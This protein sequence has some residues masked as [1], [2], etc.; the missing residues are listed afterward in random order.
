MSKSHELSRSNIQQNSINPGNTKSF[1][2]P[3]LLACNCCIR[4]SDSFGLQYSHIE[5]EGG[6]AYVCRWRFCCRWF[7]IIFSII[8]AIVLLILFLAYVPNAA[9]TYMDNGSLIPSYI[10]IQNPTNVTVDMN[11]T[12]QVVNTG[13]YDCI[14]HPTT[15]T[16]LH[17]GHKIGIFAQPQID[18]TGG[19][20]ATL[21][22]LA[23]V[24]SRSIAEREAFRN[25]STL[26]FRGYDQV[27]TFKA[28]PDVS[29]KI[30]GMKLAKVSVTMEK[31]ISLIG[32]A[33]QNPYIRNLT[34]TVMNTTSVVGFSEIEFSIAS[35]LHVLTENVTFDLYD[36]FNNHL[37]TA[38]VPKMDVVPGYNKVNN[39]RTLMTVSNTSN[40]SESNLVP[41]QTFAMN[42]L[43][44]KGQPLNMRG[45]IK[46]LVISNTI[47]T[48][49]WLYGNTVT[50]SKAIKK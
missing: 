1:N 43:G 4:R 24:H 32:S 12:L 23:K 40:T 10:A 41:M 31:D 45:P 27:I 50:Q 38:F 46:G 28:T 34:I 5:E 37:G 8:L 11:T 14:V 33:L 17:N 15:V 29:V 48:D 30:M 19:V 3:G 39:I 7:C 22:L 44:G 2:G 47:N 35:T 42:Y 25:M 6:A 26:L 18:I 49:A 16:L 21:S 13:P 36:R 9:Q 20:G